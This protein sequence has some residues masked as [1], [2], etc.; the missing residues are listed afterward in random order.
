MNTGS[1]CG[2]RVCSGSPRPIYYIMYAR[3]HRWHALL[4]P[5]SPQTMEEILRSRE[6]QPAKIEKVQVILDKL[7]DIQ[8]RLLVRIVKTSYYILYLVLVL[9]I[10]RPGSCVPAFDGHG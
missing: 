4:S 2:K 10:Y 9:T 7:A 3:F 1:D 8:Y 5:R 6:S